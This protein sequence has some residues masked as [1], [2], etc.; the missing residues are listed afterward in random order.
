MAQEG[1]DLILDDLAVALVRAG[2][3]IVPTLEPARQ[4]GADTRALRALAAASCSRRKAA[5]LSNT[6]RL[7]LPVTVEQWRRPSS[8]VQE[9][10]PIQNPSC[11]R[12]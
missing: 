5:S 9:N 4:E 11:L 6:S 10:W 3:Q 8:S 1:H 7:L 12:W 2:R